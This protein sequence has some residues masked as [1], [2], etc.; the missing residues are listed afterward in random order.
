MEKAF[1]EG[2]SWWKK[3]PKTKHIR[4]K[5]AKE[6]YEDYWDDY[7]KFS[8]IRNP[9][10]RVVSMLRFK[11]KVLPEGGDF[12]EFVQTITSRQ[13]L[14][15]FEWLGGE[16][17]FVGRFENLESDWEQL[18]KMVDCDLDLP[19]TNKSKRNEN[20]RDY[21]SND[22]RIFVDQVHE[23]DYEIFNYAF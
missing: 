11:H 9:Y 5:H 12:Q 7:F 21:Y 13:P 10:D 17:D 20:Y 14:S 2:E 16:M 15:Y 22:S 1:L 8:F 23:P 3:E 4:A 19:H 18:C 6:I